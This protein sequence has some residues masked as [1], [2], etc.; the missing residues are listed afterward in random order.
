MSSTEPTPKDRS[1]HKAMRWVWALSLSAAM[2]LVVALVFLLA[3]TSGHQD[4]YARYFRWLVIINITITGLLMLAL[5][6]ATVRLI[7]RLKEGRFGSRLLVKLAAVFAL[8]GIFPGVLVYAV[9]YQFVSRSIETWFDVKVEGALAAGLKLGQVSYDAQVRDLSNK[10]QVMAYQLSQ[11][12]EAAAVLQLDRIRQQLEVDDVTLLGLNGEVLG[13]SG[14]SSYRLAPERMSSVQRAEIVQQRSLYGIDGGDDGAAPQMWAM[15]VVPMSIYDI[16]GQMRILRVSTTM[17]AALAANAQAVQDAY[18]EYQERALGREGLRRMY[19]GTLTLALIL[20]VFGAVVLAVLLGQQL[21]RPLLILAEGVKQV[22]AGDLSPKQLVH[23]HDE[24]GGLTHAFADMTS[25]LRE[26]QEVAQSSLEQVANARAH[27]QTILDNLTTGVVVLDRKGV[28]QSINNGAQR[29][30]QHELQPQLGEALLA[31]PALAGFGTRVAEHFSALPINQSA[32]WQE[33]FEFA[34]AQSGDTITI[35][36]RGAWLSGTMQLLVIDDITDIISAQ[37]SVAW[38]EVARRLAHEIKNPLTPIQLSAERIEHK[39][40]D[41]LEPADKAVLQRSVRVIVEQV[42]AM[43]RLVN[44]FR[45]YARLPVAELKPLDLN[46]I[47]KDVMQL[48]LGAQQN[49]ILQIQTNCAADLPLIK[50]DTA[51]LRQVLHNLL[52]NA[53]DAV[54]GR[55][56]QKISVET[57]YQ[58]PQ[59]ETP[60]T[61]GKICFS[62]SD[63]GCGFSERILKRAFEPYVT[64]KPK[65]TGLGLAVVK[66]IMDEHGARIDLRNHFDAQ[67]NISGAQVLIFFPELSPAATRSQTI[68]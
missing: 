63:T 40:A 11:V 8:V 17:P 26:A 31:V 19:I 52:Q 45:E 53:L 37:R 7:V 28:V 55:D 21:L 68:E 16:S 34:D 51:Q 58:K 66:K 44:E 60:H 64:T 29:I 36:A 59:G 54:E 41:K 42:D 57:T 23:T 22:G 65:G 56:E 25:Q 10:T 14:I 47:V 39:F 48:Y 43:K 32:Y 38:G 49:P 3:Q 61:P 13:A 27:L 67:G 15:V 5:V 9:S 6:W 33:T 18:T 35:V 4:L 1:V 46:A 20:A 2:C 50:G 12:S 24:L 30:L 62:I